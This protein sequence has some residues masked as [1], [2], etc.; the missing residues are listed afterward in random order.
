LKFISKR[1]SVACSRTFPLPRVPFPNRHR[2]LHHLVEVSCRPALVFISVMQVSL[3]AEIHPL[4]HEPGAVSIRKYYTYLICV[5]QRA[6]L[7]PS[8]FLLDPMS[9]DMNR[10]SVLGISVTADVFRC[11]IAGRLS[12]PRR[13]G[14]LRVIS[15]CVNLCCA[16]SLS[17]HDPTLRNSSRKRS[18]FA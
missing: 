6:R 15:G 12:P 4:S 5:S 10:N 9:T 7:P 11:N 13:L 17:G 1:S 14:Y 18:F 3:T 8:S 2:C 16:C